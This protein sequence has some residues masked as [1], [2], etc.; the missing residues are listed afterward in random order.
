VLALLDQSEAIQGRRK[1]IDHLRKQAA[2][3][4]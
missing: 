3:K 1:E 4:C 2:K